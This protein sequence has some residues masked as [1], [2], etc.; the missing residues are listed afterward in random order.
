MTK[1]YNVFEVSDLGVYHITSFSAEFKSK[2]HAQEICDLLNQYEEEREI[3]YDKLLNQIIDYDEISHSN[4]YYGLS[5]S[6]EDL[7]EDVIL[8]FKDPK[9]F[10]VTHECD[11]C[12]YYSE[13]NCSKYNKKVE[14]YYGSDCEGFSWKL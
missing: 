3:I 12:E 1:K 4:Y 10:E 13:N 8:L 7:K 9:S 11:D 2:R 5:E 6:V 14:E